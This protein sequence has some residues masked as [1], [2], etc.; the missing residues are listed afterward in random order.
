MSIVE[1][2]KKAKELMEY[3][4]DVRIRIKPLRTSLASVSLTKGVITLDPKV[5][6]LNE[7]VVLYIL[8]HEIAHLKAKTVFHSPI[9]REE[10]KKIFTNEK[11]EELE[12]AALSIKLRCA[13]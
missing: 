13:E 12:K 3:N 1:I 7:E 4:E 5:L 10:I 2:L 11:S 6:K 9:F 8:V